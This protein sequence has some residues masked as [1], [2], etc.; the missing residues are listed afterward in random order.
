[1]AWADTD[2][3]VFYIEINE[4]NDVNKISTIGKVKHQSAKG[5]QT[6]IKEEEGGR[7]GGG[8]GVTY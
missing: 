7:V 4:I 8:E 2:N 5:K 1:M 6:T 3:P